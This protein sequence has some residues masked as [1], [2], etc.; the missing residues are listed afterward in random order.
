MK[1]RLLCCTLFSLFG[2]ATHPSE[3]WDQETLLKES[4]VMVCPDSSYVFG[5]SDGQ[6]KECL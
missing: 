5:T 1:T 3:S 2:C 6:L 4:N